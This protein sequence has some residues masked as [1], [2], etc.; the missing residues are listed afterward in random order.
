MN[1]LLSNCHPPSESLRTEVDAPFW[2]ITVTVRL[3]MWS[4]SPATIRSL[5]LEEWKLFMSRLSQ[6]DWKW[7]RLV[8]HLCA[9]SREGNETLI[10]VLHVIFAHFF[11]QFPTLRRCKWHNCVINALCSLSGCDLPSYPFICV[12]L[13]PGKFVQPLFSGGCW[14]T[15][16]GLENSEVWLFNRNSAHGSFFCQQFSQHQQI[17]YFSL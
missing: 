12:Y 8:P 17:I 9:D 5:F 3:F 15:N 2:E 16:T 13:Q 14:D 10:R 6:L 4:D 11:V 1:P 7:L